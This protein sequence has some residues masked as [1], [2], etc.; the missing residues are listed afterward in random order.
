MGRYTL[1]YSRLWDRAVEYVCTN[2]SKEHRVYILETFYTASLPSRSQRRLQRGDATELKS[3]NQIPAFYGTTRSFITTFKRAAT[4][5]YS[6]PHELR[7]QFRILFLNIHFNI[8]LLNNIISSLM[9]CTPHQLF[10]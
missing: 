10:G 5:S 4:G 6:K 7:S 1:I 9:I 2:F 3:R 8:I